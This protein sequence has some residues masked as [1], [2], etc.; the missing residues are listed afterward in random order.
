[1]P[2]QEHGRSDR[3][4]G[5]TWSP[6][7]RRRTLSRGGQASG[8]VAAHWLGTMPQPFGAQYLRQHQLATGWDPDAHYSQLT[9]TSRALLDFSFAPGLHFSLSQAAVPQ[10][11]NSLSLSALSNAL[12]DGSAV[13]GAGTGEESSSTPGAMTGSLTYVMS[14]RGVKLRSSRETALRDVVERFRI[15]TMPDQRV[16]QS[17]LREDSS[18]LLCPCAAGDFDLMLAAKARTICSTAAFTCRPTVL[19]PSGRGISLRPRKR[20]SRSCPS[21]NTHPGPPAPAPP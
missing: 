11:A 10:V 3:A 20:L 7:P 6:P 12:L 16:G 4:R 18:A 17:K 19:T 9:R 2:I 15:P 21:L 5:T 14:S 1:M 8:V 13:G